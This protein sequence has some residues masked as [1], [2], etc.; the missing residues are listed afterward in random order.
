MLFLFLFFFRKEINEHEETLDRSNIRDF[1]DGYLAE[2]QNRKGDPAFCSKY[3]L[4][5][6]IFHCV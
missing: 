6:Q 4:Q 5:F 2:I 1:I 3:P